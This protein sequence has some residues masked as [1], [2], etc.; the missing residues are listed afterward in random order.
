MH[1]TQQQSTR[2]WSCSFSLILLVF[3]FTFSFFPHYFP[4]QQRCVS[5]MGSALRNFSLTLQRVSIMCHFKVIV[6]SLSYLNREMETIVMVMFC[7]DDAISSYTSTAKMVRPSMGQLCGVSCH[8]AATT[9]PSYSFQ[10]QER[11]DVRWLVAR[12]E[13]LLRTLLWTAAEF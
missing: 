4:L 8:V 10:L 6:S 3:S 1:N 12:T 7:S 9:C 2:D 5:T 11:D 13:G